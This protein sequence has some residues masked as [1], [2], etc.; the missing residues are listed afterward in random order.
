MGGNKGV[1]N[2]SKVWQEANHHGNINADASNVYT[3]KC[4]KAA[5][6]ANPGEFQLSNPRFTSVWMLKANNA[7]YTCS[8]SGCNLFDLLIQEH[9]FEIISI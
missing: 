5:T 2:I 4:T 1:L 7:K 8:K 3:L 6:G 9:S